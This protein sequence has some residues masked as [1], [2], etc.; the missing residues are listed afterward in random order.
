MPL[1][2]IFPDGIRTAADKSSFL[3]VCNCEGSECS[4]THDGQDL[5]PA[6]SSQT[7]KGESEMSSS[8][9]NRLSASERSKIADQINAA[10]E[11]MTIDERQNLVDALT[12][13]LAEDLKAKGAN[14]KKHETLLRIHAAENDVTHGGKAELQRVNNDLRNSGV[15]ETVQDLAFMNVAKVDAIMAS[16]P[17]KLDSIKRTAIKR[18]LERRLGWNGR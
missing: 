17:R 10:N 8:F 16:A 3:A 5:I 13:A 9:L 1:T 6:I 12:V 2:P 7:N 11:H 14:D 18:V 4:C 15:A